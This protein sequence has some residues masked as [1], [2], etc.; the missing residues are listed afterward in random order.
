MTRIRSY[1]P[2]VNCRTMKKS[3][4]IPE[5]IPVPS[6]KE[7]LLASEMR[8]RRLFESAKDGILILDAKT[9]R[10]L[11]VNPFLTNLLG[12]SRENIID[13]EIW[14]IGFFRDIAANKEKFLELQNNEY[15]RYDNLPLETI[16]GRKINVEFVSN[17]Y[18]ENNLKIIQCNIRDITERKKK[19]KDLIEAENALAESEIKYR[20]FF[21]N[22]MD[23]IL[24][25][26]YDEK[27]I[28][29]NRAACCLFG[30]SADELTE[31]GRSVVE[32]STDPRLNVLMAERAL[33]GEA[34]GEVTLVH[35]NGI[36][37]PAEIS[38]SL[39]KNNGG[40]YLASMIIHDIT[41]RKQNE[42]Q[43]I[44]AKDDA[45]T[46]DHLKSSFLANMSHE[47]RTP[48]NGILG[49][50]ELLKEPMLSGE[51]QK[52]YIDIIEKSGLRMLNIINDIISISKIE[53]GETDLN[54][55]S[56]DINDLIRNLVETYK[57][58][59]AAKNI[60]LSLMNLLPEN[61]S[62]VKT[63]KDKVGAILINLI[64]NA[65]KFTQSGSIEAGC[66]KKAEELEFY[67]KDTGIGV[68]RERSEIIFER[69][70]QGS[71]SLSRNY[72]GA[73]LGLSISKGYV[74]MLGGRI[75][76]EN[77]YDAT[78]APHGSIFYFTIPYKA[79]DE[80]KVKM[81]LTEDKKKEL[82]ILIVEDDQISEMLISMF[83]RQISKHILKVRSGTE[84]VE[85]CH[86][87]PDIDLILMDIKMPEMD[88]Y[89]ATRQIR[90]FNKAVII[91][92]Q[93]AY[94]LPGEIEKA[95]DAGCNDYISKPVNQTLLNNMI[96]K[97]VEKESS[98]LPAP[99]L[100]P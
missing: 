19:E 92:A 30:Y 52:E 63:D 59:A 73:G 100:H 38:T 18:L 8:Y 6:L 25:T 75:W 24:L 70:R 78:A 15:I 48:M 7:E 26:G 80:M 61:Q 91:I 22:S 84:A 64:K 68:Q 95:I 33:Q 71:E 58:E 35:K 66:L 74:A 81:N 23:A 37:F 41:D 98:L 77:N 27:I 45:E 90:K 21:E 14:E 1:L 36:R 83:V 2:R 69:F 76:V 53:S 40:E 94:G 44:K 56:V 57:T 55:A 87:Y 42:I 85:A 60:R 39:F 89:E 99:S 11:D 4:S 12:F 82:K 49:F 47:I 93:T 54:M 20:S 72:E 16:D 9:G 86:S 34:K 10:I 67:V 17:V 79:A 96:K 13:K 50:T 88:G 5:N 65:I 51:E 29:V 32:D 62:F 3:N 46:S 28:S 43:L 97:Y 31:L